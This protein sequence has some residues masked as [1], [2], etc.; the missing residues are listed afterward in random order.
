MK[1]YFQALTVAL[2]LLPVTLCTAQTGA[3]IPMD[4]SY[5]GYRLSEVAIPDARVGVF[6]PLDGD[7]QRA[8]DYVSTLAPDADGMRGAVLLDKGVYTL[9]EPLRL[10]AS[11]VVI[12]GADRHATVLRKVGVERNA[13]LYIEGRNDYRP[14]GDAV[15]VKPDHVVAGTQQ[16]ELTAADGF[17]P[18]DRVTVCRPSTAAWIA[19]MGCN[20][21]GDGGA[22]GWKQGDADLRWDRT[23]RAVDGDR[24]LL[25]APITAALDARYGGGTVTRY[26]WQGRIDRCGVENLTLVSVYDTDYPKDEDHAWVGVSIDNAQDCWVRRVTFK[27]F[28]GS[29]VAIQP[30]ASRVTVEDCV[31]QAPVSEIGGGRRNTFLTMGQLC[32]IQ[33]CYS[34]HGIH[35]FAVAATAPG[36]NAFVQCD[37]W[38]SL[39]FSGSVDAWACGVLYDIVN[40]DGNDLRFENLWNAFGG[41]GWNAANSLFWQCTAAQIACFSPAPDARNSAYGCWA[42]VSGNGE[43]GELNSHVSPRSIFYAQ[44]SK[45]LPDDTTAMQRARLLPRNTSATSSPTVEMAMQLAEESH[46]PRLTLPMWIEQAPFGASTSAVGV[47]SIDQVKQRLPAKLSAAAPALPVQLKEGHLTRDGVLLAGAR[48]EVQW[49][50]GSVRAQRLPMMRPHVTRFV[51][52]REGLGLTD[53]IDSVIARLKAYNVLLLDHNYG[54]WYDRRRDDHE[55]IRRRTGDVWPPHYEQPFARSGRD[56]AWDGLSKYDLTRYNRWYWARLRQFA[57]AGERAG[58]LL[59]HENYFQHNILEAGAHWVDC[60]WRTANNVNSTPFPEPVPFAGDKRIFMAEQFYDITNPVLRDLHRRYIRQCLSNFADNSNVVQLTSAEFTG[61]LRFVQFWLDVVAEWERETGK[62]PLI[63]LSATKDVQDAILAD[64]LR[65]RTV[66]IIDIRYWHYKSD[67]TTYDPRGG[68]NMAPRQHARKMKVGKV[69]FAD[70]Y[71]AVREYRLRYPDKAVTFFAQNY[72]AQAWAVLMAG[73]SCPSLPATTD[74]DFLKAAATMQPRETVGNG[75]VQL[76][77]SGTGS[78]IYSQSD[79]TVSV[80]M[81]AGKYRL[82]RIDPTTGKATLMLRSLRCEELVTLSEPGIYWYKKL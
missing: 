40:I 66:D 32:L 8:I 39:G 26:D 14:T 1:S 46:H 7:I 2:L 9:R 55:R 63:A 34:E 28:C 36:P 11:G 48:Q 80:K 78:I 51:P 41:A 50:S 76:V 62:H 18:G 27:H 47:P 82:Y 60:P 37:T 73:G 17:L 45:R 65:S 33:R 6:V 44:L 23:V 13:L 29:A 19:L 35:D 52:C 74:R 70:A 30:A 43:W 68:Q 77:N 15:R 22:L 81:P 31:A 10:T 16:L 58:V 79:M 20:G 71:R 72:P 21:F 12:R 64:T 5:C 53:R 25:D 61:P 56:T 42:Q 67:G 57:D 38:E 54:L 4:Y 59:F 3:Y 69:T 75:F 49:W 24:I